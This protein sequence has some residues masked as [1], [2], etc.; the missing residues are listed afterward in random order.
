[1]DVSVIKEI[2]FSRGFQLLRFQCCPFSV[3]VHLEADQRVRS[4]RHPDG[5]GQA[6][7]PRHQHRRQEAPRLARHGQADGRAEQGHQVHLQAGGGALGR[8]QNLNV[9][10]KICRRN[11]LA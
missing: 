7:A 9:A 11:D 1:M 4:V 10:K 3:A 8:A 5:G 6:A 2:F